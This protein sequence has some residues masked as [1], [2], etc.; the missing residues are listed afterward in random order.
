MQTRRDSMLGV[1]GLS[2]SLLLDLLLLAPSSR[3]A[4]SDP[5]ERFNSLLEEFRA[6]PD[7]E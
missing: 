7:L 4:A 2:G 1:V 6:S 3:A 5:T